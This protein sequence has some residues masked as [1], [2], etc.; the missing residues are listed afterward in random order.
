MHKLKNYLLLGLI[1]LIAFSC[2]K[3]EV[4]NPN[5]EK[6]VVA[7]SI[8][9]TMSEVGAY[10]PTDN[11]RALITSKGYTVPQ[12]N[13]T[14]EEFKAHNIP[15]HFG[16]F[17]KGLTA[18]LKTIATPLDSKPSEITE[19][20]FLIEQPT[21]TESR[22]LIK[23]YCK[24]PQTL[25]T[26][27]AFSFLALDGKLVN[28]KL[29]YDTE[30]G[31]SP[32]AIIKGIKNG[33]TDEG[34]HLPIITNILPF[35]KVF[36]PLTKESIRFNPRGV[37]IGICLIN[38]LA[39]DVQINKITFEQD[40]ALFFEG[41]FD[42]TK[43]IASNDYATLESSATSTGEAMLF[44]GENKEFTFPIVQ[45]ENARLVSKAG[46][47]VDMQ[48]K[49]ELP[50]FYVWG[51]PRSGQSSIK[52]KLHL[53]KGGKE[54]TTKLLS[55][56]IPRAGFI[57]GKAYRLPILI[58]KDIL[59]LDEIRVRNPLDYWAEYD[60]AYSARALRTS[61]SLPTSI[62]NLQPTDVGY[63]T[64]DQTQQIY[65][66]NQT[67]FLADYVIP[68]KLQAETIF[69]GKRAITFNIKSQ[70]ET[71]NL[72]DEVQIGDE[73]LT[74]PSDFRQKENSAYIYYALRFKDNSKWKSAWR[75]RKEGTNLIVDC[76]AGVKVKDI[77][78]DQV[79]DELFTGINCVTRI[80]PAYGY[81]NPTIAFLQTTGTYWTST[82]GGYTGAG[83]S[84]YFHFKGSG[85]T[86][87][88][89]TY[90]LGSQKNAVRPYYKESAVRPII[91]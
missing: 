24:L 26:D 4:L 53:T 22:T 30:N 77:T 40:N 58:T 76:V 59:P 10:T 89:N 86:A 7:E 6:P 13:V 44:N 5:N 41:N 9:E 43:G 91:Q 46:A 64:F 28:G 37:Q 31:T 34:R 36:A 90:T 1:S 45:D 19:D 20:A 17:G 14:T 8:F 72:S 74:S 49:G 69:P 56:A 61:H 80:F 32:N 54:V 57:E 12:L 33:A 25:A 68:N 16:I 65:N 73:Q 23:T 27:K 60:I 38:Q 71:L 82:E 50:L 70:T 35:S 84:L 83:T 67:G 15:A 18:T 51:F 52:L 42:C 2:D 11:M 85:E 48:L 88:I 75:Y 63:F 29:H 62:D 66:N 21:T 78:I 55:L 87:S 47:T 39:E 81:I 3:E 79:T